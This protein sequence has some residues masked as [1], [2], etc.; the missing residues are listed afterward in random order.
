[1]I[2]LRTKFAGVKKG[3]GD[4]T[5]AYFVGIVENITDQKQTELEMAELRR[6]LES[7]IEV[8]RLRLAQELHDGPMQELYGVSYR[9]E[10]L[11]AQM[12]GLWS[13][14]L[15]EMNDDI[16]KTLQR[17]RTLAADLRPASISDFGLEKAIRSYVEDFQHKYPI[18][19]IKLS[20]AQDRQLLPENMRMTL[21]RV[22]QQSMMNIVRHAQA[23]EVQVRFTLDAEEARLEVVDNGKGFEVPPN[24]VKF[25]RQGHYGLAGAS[26]RVSALGGLLIVESEPTNQTVV[27]AVVPWSGSST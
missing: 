10:E 26:E 23:S 25:A 8:E 15:K 1:M 17:L 5:L 11:H 2:W 20:L 18:C 6:H 7:N 9:L 24:W 4:N 21:F 16:Q 14:K 27:R 22:F 3:G 19:N 12:D 13:G